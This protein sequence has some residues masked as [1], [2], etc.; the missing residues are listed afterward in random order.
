MDH[1]QQALRHGEGEEDL[2]T[3]Q[4][5]LN[6]SIHALE[7]LYPHYGQDEFIGIELDVQIVYYVLP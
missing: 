4:N 6:K 3:K 1:S 5:M 2:V 7:H